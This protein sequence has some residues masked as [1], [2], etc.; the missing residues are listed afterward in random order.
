MA[1]KA[2]GPCFKRFAFYSQLHAFCISGPPVFSCMHVNC[3]V[4][5]ADCCNMK[6]SSQLFLYDSQEYLTNFRELLLTSSGL[7]L[8]PYSAER[9]L[10]G[11][12][13]PMPLLSAA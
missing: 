3:S 1:A 10:A 6:K 2:V 11:I 8:Q 5:S 7:D 13:H 12:Q 4:C 9:M